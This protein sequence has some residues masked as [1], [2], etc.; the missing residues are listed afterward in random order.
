MDVFRHTCRRAVGLRRDH[1]TKH[2]R[3]QPVIRCVLAPL[4]DR[5]GDQTPQAKVSIAAALDNRSFAC[6]R[7][8][9]GD[10]RPIYLRP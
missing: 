3:N 8:L 2:S 6:D 10:Q 9:D 4:V 7:Q 1:L 5:S